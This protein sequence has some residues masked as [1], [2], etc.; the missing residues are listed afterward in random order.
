MDLCLVLAHISV[1]EFQRWACWQLTDRS[2]KEAETELMEG[3]TQG[4]T[5]NGKYDIQRKH[6]SRTKRIERAI[7]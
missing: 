2:E 5:R 7:Q 4:S 3:R 6:R 1:F